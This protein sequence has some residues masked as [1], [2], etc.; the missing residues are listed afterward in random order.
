[1]ADFLGLASDAAACK[2]ML[3]RPTEAVQIL[4]QGRSV[5][6]GKV[7]DLRSDLS[8]L[9]DRA[10]EFADMFERLT[11]E[12]TAEWVTLGEEQ[13]PA[14]S[15]IV[16]EGQA[17]DRRHNAAR[18]LD[19]LINEIRALDG[20]GDFLLPPSLERLASAAGQGPI[21]IINVSRYRS[22]ALIV[23][24][25]GIE[26]VPLPDLDATTVHN[27]TLDF[28]AAIDS[29]ERTGFED[30]IQG[31]RGISAILEWLWESLGEPVLRKLDY[32]SVPRGNGQWPRVFW[33]PTGL[34]SLLPIHAAGYHHDTITDLNPPNCDG[35]GG[36]VL[37]HH[38][39]RAFMSYESSDS[40]SLNMH[41]E[42]LIVSLP[43]T[44]GAAPLPGAAHETK[45]LASTF[46]GASILSG[47]NATRAA[48]RQALPT[49]TWAHFACHAT[50]DL[51]HPVNSGLV[52]SDGLTTRARHLEDS[53]R[54][55]RA[56]CPFGLWDWPRRP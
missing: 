28:L 24:H 4:E 35:S 21:V 16:L 10:P 9:R 8:H 39:P 3:N 19:E 48:V 2:L 54:T 23:T 29:Q 13:G 53:S 45:F 30:R 15:P 18:Q 11:H 52:L 26:V 34:L 20:F 27:R 5:L 6:L 22:D 50:S 55:G 47:R 14:L 1:M 46:P 51:D 12:I 17:S 25:G 56:C 36:L 38:R 31:Q 32:T 43:S 44:P 7:L 41:P 33:C 37:Y 40:R 42:L 49:K